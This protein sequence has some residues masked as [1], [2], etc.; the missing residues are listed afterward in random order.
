ML[1]SCMQLVSRSLPDLDLQGAA[2]YEDL[3][4]NVL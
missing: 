3:L 2:Y 4:C 1:M